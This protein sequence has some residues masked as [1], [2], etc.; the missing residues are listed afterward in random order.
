MKNRIIYFIL[1]LLPVAVCYNLGLLELRLEEPR[2]ALVALEMMIRNSYIVPQINGQLY[3]TKPPLFNWTIAL[4]FW[5]AGNKSE[6]AARLPGILSYFA[7]GVVLYWFVK[8]YFSK[9]K[10]FLSALFF[11]TASDL[12]LFGTMISA[13]IDLFFAFIITLQIIFLYH[14]FY[15]QQWLMMFAVSYIFTAL[16]VLT[17][18][19][20]AILFQGISLV[21]ICLYSRKFKLLFSWQHFA[22][23][24]CFLLVAGSYF[25]VYQ[26]TT[27]QLYNY[28]AKLYSDAA[29][30]SVLEH[31]FLKSV[32]NFLASPLHLL[33]FFAPWFLYVIFLFKKPVVS[34]GYWQN[35]TIGFITWCVA[36]NIIPMLFTADTKANYIYPLFPFMAVILAHIYLEY[37][38]ANPKLNG[39]IN[40]VFLGLMVLVTLALIAAP[41]FSI[42]KNSVSLLWLKTVLMVC[43]FAGIAWL[44]YKSPS[45]SI[46]LLILFMVAV[47][48]TVSMYY[49]PVYKLNSK[50]QQFSNFTKTITRQAGGND[51]YLG[52]NP[53]IQKAFIA[54]GPLRFD[55]VNITMPPFIPFQAPFYYSINNKKVMQYD[56]ELRIGRY[57]L[58][59]T[60]GVPDTMKLNVLNRFQPSVSKKEVFYLV[61]PKQVQSF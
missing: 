14:F 41:F 28:M 31:S 47:R 56:P 18:G 6:W 8:K 30:K 33:R 50:Q 46:Y 16:G 5:L 7:T 51:I 10:A 23:I 15:R 44:F 32:L 13:E 49:L 59:F 19:I 53:D 38:D 40:A 45:V 35:H 12:L 3:Y 22:G 2:R 20:P 42:I 25:Y 60:T 34:K 24:L 54:V 61:T 55:T 27:G 36:I 43:L 29:E 37:K 1:I 26:Q 39:V 11:F 48:L 17:K 9:E 58:L 21:V 57:Y 52:G 4:S